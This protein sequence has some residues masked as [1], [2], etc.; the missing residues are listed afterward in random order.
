M[1]HH[2]VPLLQHPHDDYH[3]SPNRGGFAGI[4]G[5]LFGSAGPVRMNVRTA[6]SVF[7][8]G[9]VIE[10]VVEL[11]VSQP[12][13]VCCINLV[14]EGHE[15]AL[16][17]HV[18]QVPDGFR[19]EEQ[20]DGTFREVPKYREVIT[21]RDRANPIFRQIIT[22]V[23]MYTP[24]QGGGSGGSG[25]F[26]QGLVGAIT[27]NFARPTV[28]LPPG[29]WTYPFQLQ[30]PTGLPPSYV[31]GT[32]FHNLFNR[33][34]PTHNPWHNGNKHGWACGVAYWLM[35][36]VDL[37][38][39]ADVTQRTS[40]TVINMVPHA[41]HSNPGAL[42]TPKHFDLTCCCCIS[43]GSV[44]ARLGLSRT[45][46]ALD[47]DVITV[48]ADVDNSKGEAKLNAIGASL[49]STLTAT[50]PGEGT[51]RAEISAGS[52]TIPLQ[53]EAG[54]TRNGVQGT[55]RLNP[56]ATPSF[57]GAFTKSEY[58]IKLTLDVDWA[59][60]EDVHFPVYVVQSVDA[61]GA[62]AQAF[63]PQAQAYG[64]PSSANGGMM[65]PSMQPQHYYY[66]PPDGA[67][68]YAAPPGMA[69]PP[70]VAALLPPPVNTNPHTP[71]P[72]FQPL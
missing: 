15:A 32:S 57:F 3:Q 66:Q 5:Q 11:Q 17:Q 49:T 71:P 8:P 59:T 62:F 36:H 51:K 27:G 67:A 14:L 45:L 69:P 19:R 23:G 16:M 40:V 18:E 52:M 46:I 72:M 43:R 38:Q 37:L 56:T 29:N 10:G 42:S 63:N 2:D 13:P 54:Q 60:D 35:G 7:Y 50:I 31:H 30:L 64:A 1:H 4:L 39:G 47:R 34:N 26:L 24:G 68:N 25:G 28:T 53:L 12:T 9:N 33:T 61:S 58:H 21:M 41:Q 55:M 44:D 70:S 20:P 65:G 6:R 48:V 22:L